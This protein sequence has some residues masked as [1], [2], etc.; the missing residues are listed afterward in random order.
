MCVYL[1]HPPQPVEVMPT[2]EKHLEDTEYQQS[3]SDFIRAKYGISK[4]FADEETT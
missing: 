1:S 2:P 3:Y 4:P